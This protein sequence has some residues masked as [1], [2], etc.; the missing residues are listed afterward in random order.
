MDKDK[1]G[2]VSYEEFIQETKDEEFDKDEEWKP[3]TEE[4]QFTD[5]EYQE[6]ERLLAQGEQVR[7][8]SIINKSQKKFSAMTSLEANCRGPPFANFQKF[9]H[10]YLFINTPS[11]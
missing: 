8:M 6:Y 1:D 3:L 7:I 4:D 10:L 5:E 9:H 11:V 2:L